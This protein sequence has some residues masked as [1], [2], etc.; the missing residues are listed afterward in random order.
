MPTIT[1]KFERP[2]GQVAAK[3]LE[4]LAA[5]LL[6]QGIPNDRI[7]QELLR[8]QLPSLQ[9]ELGRSQGRQTAERGE[10]LRPL[11]RET[12]GL[13]GQQ[14][15][16][17]SAAAS[18]AM[19]GAGVASL[20]PLLM[21]RLADIQRR[22]SQEQQRPKSIFEAVSPGHPNYGKE[23]TSQPRFNSLGQLMAAASFARPGATGTL[24]GSLQ[25]AQQNLMANR[26][27]QL[28]ANTAA[29]AARAQAQQTT[30]RQN[31]LGTVI[32]AIQNQYLLP[33][34]I[35]QIAATL[36]VSL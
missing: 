13:E 16:S 26:A 29:L 34:D 10:K 24:S 7:Q 23:Q 27:A 1:T 21:Q 20:E 4:Q 32:G 3:D 36:G 18:A 17:Q 12:A 25:R 6:A 22:V 35:E 11:F 5:L 14:A 31:I 15:A 9:Q 30:Q 28:S 8:S 2:G 33:A 19:H